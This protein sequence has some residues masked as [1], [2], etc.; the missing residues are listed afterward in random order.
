LPGLAVFFGSRSGNYVS[1]CKWY[2]ERDVHTLV[3][4]GQDTTLCDCNV[5]QK[6]VQFFVVS[7]GKLQ[8][9]RNDTCLLVVSGSVASQFQD[10]GSKILKNGSEVDR[11]TSTDTLGI[12]SF[13]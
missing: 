10:F 8:V 3:N 13:S 9:S 5:T 7:D 4:V 12:V 6:L 1:V 2:E 11:G